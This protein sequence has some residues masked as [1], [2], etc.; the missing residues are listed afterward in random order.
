MSKFPTGGVVIWVWPG[1]RGGC[2]SVVKKKISVGAA[3]DPSCER[4]SCLVFF[5]RVFPLC[6]LPKLHNDPPS[7]F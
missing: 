2:E 5:F 7:I 6:C 1:K 3:A 4:G